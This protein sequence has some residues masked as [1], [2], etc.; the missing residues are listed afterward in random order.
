MP[1]INGFGY[2]E[3]RKIKSTIL[4]AR[5]C[6][7]KALREAFNNNDRFQNRVMEFFGTPTGGVEAG[8]HHIMKTINSM[9]LVIDSDVYTIENGGGKDGTNAEALN[10]QQGTVSFKGNA[11]KQARTARFQGTRFYAGK[12][13]NVIE[14][15]FDYS[16]S[17]GALPITLFHEYFKL[18]YKIGKA[19]SQVETF[20]HELS[21]T[22]AGT[23]DVDA[24][25]C[26]GY[27]GV[28]HC[29]MLGKG[30]LNAET[31]GMFL[32]SYLI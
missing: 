9:K 27:Q 21:H 1:K 19:R 16:G 20:L 8:N 4:D 6:I 26:Y 31:Y 5:A 17:G 14:A 10:F 24:P 18:P 12:M 15:A 11:Q 3:K 28:V 30:A 25:M 2:F 29:K 13:V 23:H 32:Q 22:S 7:D